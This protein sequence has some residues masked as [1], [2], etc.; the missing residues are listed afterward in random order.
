MGVYVR[1][2]DSISIDDYTGVSRRRR[3]VTART[4]A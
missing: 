1:F 3:A 2:G 4:E